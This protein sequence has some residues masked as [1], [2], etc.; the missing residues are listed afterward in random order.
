MTVEKPIVAN[1]D[2]FIFRTAVKFMDE[3]E[4]YTENI[5]RPDNCPNGFNYDWEQNK[6]TAD[7]ISN[8]YLAFTSQIALT[9]GATVNNV[10]NRIIFEKRRQSLEVLKLA[11]DDRQNDRTNC[12]CKHR[13]DLKKFA[14]EIKTLTGMK[15][16]VDTFSAKIDDVY[17]KVYGSSLP[18]YDEKEMF[19]K[20]AV[21]ANGFRKSSSYEKI[22]KGSK[23]SK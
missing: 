15:K 5:K 21:K 20:A 11:V 22:H 23:G 10:S 7:A 14:E 17:S 8:A 6:R 4:G 13:P 1:A 18:K 19:P 12:E 16:M 2:L 3:W 9:S